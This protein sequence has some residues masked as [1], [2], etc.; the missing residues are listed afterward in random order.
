[1]ASQRVVTA[2]HPGADGVSR[3]DRKAR[4]RRA[5]LDAALEL[6][7]R[8]RGYSGLSLREIAKA[9]GVVPAAFYRHFESTEELG[10]ALVEES[11]V[12]IRRT[13]REVREVPVPTR[14]LIG[15]SVDAFLGYVL[16]HELHFRFIMKERYGGSATLRTA[17]RQEVRLFTSELATDLARAPKLSHVST[18]DLQLVAALVVQTVISATELTLDTRPEDTAEL[19]RIAADAQAQLLIIF[20]GG[21]RWH[22]RN[23]DEPD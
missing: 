13:M 2:L 9:A 15:V 17:I 12:T 14:H 19:D 22:G 20:I 8:D 23:G 6:T 10:L 7:S 3:D 18:A 21:E 11:F 1:M 5:L 4:T 16:E